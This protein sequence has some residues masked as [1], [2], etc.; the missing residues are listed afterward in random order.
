MSCTHTHRHNFIIY[1]NI[2]CKTKKKTLLTGEQLIA[3]FHD[4]FNNGVSFLVPYER[5]VS[6]DLAA[7]LVVLIYEKNRKKERKKKK[8]TETYVLSSLFDEFNLKSKRKKILFLFCVCHLEFLEL[9]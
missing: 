5:S 6:Y 7:I 2:L 4:I 1:N 3:Q 8:R 9:I